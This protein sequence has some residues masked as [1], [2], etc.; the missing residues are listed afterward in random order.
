M[1][2]ANGDVPAHLS[3]DAGAFWRAVLDGYELD[4]GGLRLL[5]GACEALDRTAEAREAVER[6]GAYPLDRFGQVKA[7][8]ALREERESRSQFE[9]HLRALGLDGTEG[10]DYLPPPRLPERDRGRRR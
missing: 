1:E 6:D 2:T 4:A 8:P 3:A 10:G 7:H 5:R 9:R